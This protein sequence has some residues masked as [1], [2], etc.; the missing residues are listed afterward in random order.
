[1]TKYDQPRILPNLLPKLLTK[2]SVLKSKKLP[3]DFF[4]SGNDPH[5]PT[6][7]IW[8]FK[9]KIHPFWRKQASFNAGVNDDGD[10][11]NVGVNDDNDDESR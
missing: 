5:P 4:R 8:I 3:I 11:V 10:V 9:T 7:L 6:P 2:I 1:M